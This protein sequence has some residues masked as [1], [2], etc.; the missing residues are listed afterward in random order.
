MWPLLYSWNFWSQHCLLHKVMHVL[1]LLKAAERE[2]LS[3]HLLAL[4]SWLISCN[5]MHP[6]HFCLPFFLFH[7]FPRCFWG[8]WSAGALIYSCWFI[9]TLPYFR[10]FS[11]SHVNNLWLSQR[12]RELSWPD[13]QPQMKTGAWCF[14]SHDLNQRWCPPWFIHSPNPFFLSVTLLLS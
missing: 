12:C 8:I 7:C 4:F 11:I 3:L 6:L 14:R 9:L 13:L 5:W 2:W 10:N 1:S